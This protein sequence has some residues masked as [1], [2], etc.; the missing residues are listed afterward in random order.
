MV[1]PLVTY[2]CESWTVVFVVQLLSLCLTLCDPM[3][4]SMPG[5]PVHHHVPEFVQAHVQWVSDATQPSYPLLSEELM[6]SNY[7]AG[8]DSWESLG[9]QE[10][11]PVNLKGNQPWIR[12]QYFGHL[13]QTADTLE[14]SL[15][16]GK[17]EGKGEE[18]IR[19]WDGWML[20]DMNLGKLREMERDREAWC[21]AVHQV[22]KSQTWLGNWT[23]ATTE[24]LRILSKN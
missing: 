4:C 16:L 21:A 17:I 9:H 5:F 12:L 10:I 2:G 6:S 15:M 1:F 20:I 19:G 11:K 3:D 23:T 13:M 22:T 8:E 7:G 24:K 18:G 14:K